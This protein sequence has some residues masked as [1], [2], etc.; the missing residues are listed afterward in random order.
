MTGVRATYHVILCI[1]GTGCVAC[2]TCYGSAVVHRHTPDIKRVFN[3]DLK[4]SDKVENGNMDLLLLNKGS[5][6]TN[7]N[8]IVCW[9]CN[10]EFDQMP[11]IRACF[12]PL[13][14]CYGADCTHFNYILT[15]LTNIIV[16]AWQIEY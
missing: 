14:H 15:E 16:Y 8:S 1:H 12:V 13:H 4:W 7:V 2:P 10:D 5:T 6:L 9:F 3:L 11:V